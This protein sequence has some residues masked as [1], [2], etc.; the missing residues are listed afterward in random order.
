MAAGGPCPRTRLTASHRTCRD[1]SNIPWGA[2]GVDVVVEA[3]GVFL[4]AEKAQAH[5]DGG[6]KKV[7]TASAFDLYHRFH[8]AAIAV[9]DAWGES[10]AR[11]HGLVSDNS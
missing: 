7:H 5:I 4:T 3:S 10:W 6:A 8:G 11:N 2:A 1:P 9:P